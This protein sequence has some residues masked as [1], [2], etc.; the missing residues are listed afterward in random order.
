MSIRDQIPNGITCANLFS[1]C[2]G[3][4][5][6]HQGYEVGAAFAV[7]AAG[8]FDLLDGLVARLIGASSTIGKELD[9]LADLVS[10]GVLPGLIVHHYL[11]MSS[12]AEAFPL[13]PYAAFLI[14]VFAALRLARFNLDQ[15]QEKEFKGLPVPANA[16]FWS[17]IPLAGF[18]N[19]GYTELKVPSASF[20]G[21]LFEFLID[22]LFL[23]AGI[24]LLSALMVSSLP[25]LAFKFE[26]GRWRGNEMRYLILGLSLILF[27]L[28][29]FRSIPLIVL[30]H[31]ILSI[32]HARSRS[33]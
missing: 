32:F 14:P 28:F 27:I 29:R 33:Q 7:L 11:A 9:S 12:W 10:F 24:L 3:I 20:E 26:H 13:L 30:L 21:S 22:P 2:V 4:V 16:I 17:G 25:V 18:Q 31:P 1:G 15:A 19:S 6:L 5:L 23:L 8:L